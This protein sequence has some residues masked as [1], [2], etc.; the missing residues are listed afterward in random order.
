MPEWHSLIAIRKSTCFFN[1]PKKKK[2][3]FIFVVFCAY[4]I[5]NINVCLVP[6]IV[7]F[8]DP[9]YHSAISRKPTN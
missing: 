1:L 2:K 5:R 3:F 4:K 9:L 8:S 6:L 7:G